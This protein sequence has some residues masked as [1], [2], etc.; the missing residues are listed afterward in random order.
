MF[1]CIR[2]TQ[3]NRGIVSSLV[4]SLNLKSEIK[5]EVEPFRYHF[6]Q[7]LEPSDFSGKQTIRRFL[8]LPRFSKSSTLAWSWVTVFVKADS[9]LSRARRESSVVE[10]LLSSSIK[11][12]SL[13]DTLCDKLNKENLMNCRSRGRYSIE[14][15]FYSVEP[16]IDIPQS[17]T[18][19][20]YFVQNWVRLIRW[21]R[22]RFCCWRNLFFLFLEVAKSGKPFG[23]RVS[24]M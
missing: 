13:K 14:T 7:E 22:R 18:K 8:R 17:G 3:V 20:S 6:P 11:Q 10:I 23:T 24:D 2:V 4:H 5:T 19:R 15:T 21:C 16:T 9:S 1:F 12:D